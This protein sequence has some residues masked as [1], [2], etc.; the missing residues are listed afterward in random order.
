MWTGEPAS[1]NDAPEPVQPPLGRKV[2]LGAQTAIPHWSQVLN[3]RH[4]L[5]SAGPF[6]LELF[7]GKAGITEAVFLAGVPVLPPVDI[8]ASDLVRTPVDLVDATFWQSLVDILVL[9]VVFFLHCGTPCNT[10]T[11]ARKADGGPP[12]L[13]SPQEP[14]GLEGLSEQDSG[15]VFLGNVFLDRTVEACSLVFAFGGDFLIENPLLSLLWQTPQLLQLVRSAR[16]FNL[17][18]DQCVFGTPWMKPTRFVCSNEQLDVLCVRCP[19]GHTHESLKGKVWDPSLQRMVFKTKQAQVY[20]LA[21]CATI[22]D[23]VRSIFLQELPHLKLTFELCVPAADRKR[24]LHS[25]RP[26]KEHKQADTA[27]KALFAGYQLKRGAAKPLLEVEMEPGGQQSCLLFN[28]FILFRARQCCP[29]ALD[30]AIHAVATNPS[31]VLRHRAQALQFWQHRA[32][33]LLPES[34]ARIMAHCCLALMTLHALALVMFV[35]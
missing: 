5:F 18:C 3:D 14:L 23:Q 2:E 4:W 29:P 19:G 22:A 20:P 24:A 10:F 33:A 30:A 26:W 32:E 13:R 27:Q 15:L 9:G 16:T 6:F 25:A 7:A 8:V 31:E 35:M 21:L 1:T 34:I 28:K 17:E 12:P 11:A